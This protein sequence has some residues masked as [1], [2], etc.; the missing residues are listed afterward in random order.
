MRMGN[1]TVKKL[2]DSL[3][4]NEIPKADDEAIYCEIR[5]QRDISSFAGAALKIID[6]K[7]V[8]LARRCEGKVVQDVNKYEKLCIGCEQDYIDSP[9]LF[10]CAFKPIH[11]WEIDGECR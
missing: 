2:M 1:F 10:K 11:I 3:Y 8:I 7:G 5:Y 4:G 6:E 9:G